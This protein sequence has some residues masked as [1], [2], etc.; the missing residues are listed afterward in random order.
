MTDPV[1]AAAGPQ[2]L[3]GLVVAVFVMIWLVLRTRVHA[4][5][6]LLAAASIAGLIGG[7]PANRVIDTI[8]TGFGNTLST[9]GL[10]IGLGVM[11]GRI[12]EVS[13]AGQRMAYAILRLL[14][15]ESSFRQGSW[16]VGT[17]L[18]PPYLQPARP[19]QR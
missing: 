16:R 12:L 18:Y 10:V 14:G 8:T 11:M 7:M 4:L 2:V 6:A 1:S 15:R 9:I 19:C 5:I 17:A 13:G 3:V